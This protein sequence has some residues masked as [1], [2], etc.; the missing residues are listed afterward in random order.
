MASVPPPILTSAPSQFPVVAPV[1]SPPVSKSAPS[2]SPG[3]PCGS[4]V[5]RLSLQLWL[6]CQFQSQGVLALSESPIIAPVPPPILTSAPS[7]FP[8]MAPVPPSVSTMIT[9]SES[10]AVAPV[11]PPISTSTP[12][13]SPVMA[14]TPPP[15]SKSSG[16]L[17]ISPILLAPVP[18][19]ISTMTPAIVPVFDDGS[20]D[21][22][23]LGGSL[24]RRVPSLRR[25]RY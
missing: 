14:P 12:S 15:I 1:V 6:R 4:G 20:K 11:Q 25:R 13:Q 16:A 21:S 24:T 5:L 9:P 2:Q 3:C 8:V 10:P 17:S 18:T 19:P 7:Q 22:P 23:T